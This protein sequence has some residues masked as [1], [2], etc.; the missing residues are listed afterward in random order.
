MQKTPDYKKA[1]KTLLIVP[2]GLTLLISLTS[3]G[4]SPQKIQENAEKEAQK[5]AQPLGFTLTSCTGY[6]SD[7]NNYVSCTFKDKNGQLAEGECAYDPSVN[8]GCKLKNSYNYQ[9]LPAAT[10]Q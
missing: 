8:A 7:Q 5:F 3:C 1:P 4:L 2:I 6:D 9:P 10:P